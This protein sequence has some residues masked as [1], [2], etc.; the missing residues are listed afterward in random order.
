MVAFDNDKL[1]KDYDQLLLLERLID[2]FEYELVEFKEANNDYDKNKIGQYVS[3]ISNEANLLNQQFGWL[4]FGV[5]NKDKAVVGTNYRK[6]SGLLN[7]RQEIT[8]GTNGVTF[9]EIIE[10]Y[11]ELNGEAFRVIMFKIPASPLAIPTSWNGHYYS[12]NGES[13]TSLSIDK[14]DRLRCQTQKDWSR[15]FVNDADI[16]M[17]DSDAI[18]MARNLYKKK[19]EKEH[20]TQEVDEMTDLQFL[21]KLKLVVNEKI[22]NS[23]MV[24]L[25][26]SDFDYLLSAPPIIM[27]RLFDANGEDKDYKIFKTPF[28]FVIDKIFQNIRN[29]TYRYMPNQSTLFPTDTQQYDTWLLR[30]L[31]NNCI[32]HM[33][34]T[35]GGRIY[36]DEFDD[37]IKFSNPGVFLPGEI[38]PIL[39]PG[40]NPPFYRNQLLSSSMVNLNMIDTA[41]MG[42][43]KVYKIQKSKYFP[44]PD[45]DFSKNQVAVTVY[46]KIINENYTK[47]LFQNPNYD[48]DTIFLIDKVQKKLELTNEQIKKLRKLGVIEGKKP[49]IYISANLAKDIKKEASYVK[50]TAFDD[51]YYKDMI[52]SYLEKFKKASK[53]DIKD[54]LFDKLPDILSDEQKDSKIRNML[55]SMKNAGIIE[56]NGNNNRTSQWILKDIV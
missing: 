34:Y 35:I 49:N 17:L 12:R 15:E 37:V 45:Y 29:L 54:L 56:R 27:W 39:E 52:Y 23:A 10:L 16:S 13:L 46:G 44:L 51:Q 1:E 2:R 20:I 25:G 42:I 5:R 14:L 7:L 36:V 33:D 53:K 26:N 11:P 38:K 28:I 24:L 18:A 22:T 43:R 30:E 50:N 21:S 9:S 55:Q 31:M 19:M 32:A 47:V 4:I 41:T 40:Y 3:A 48:L 8:N 6:K